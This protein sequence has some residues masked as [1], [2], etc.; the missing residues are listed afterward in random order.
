MKKK[1][2]AIFSAAVILTWC[3]VFA[4]CSQSI[5]KDETPVYTNPLVKMQALSIGWN[6][7]YYSEMQYGSA[8][9]PWV[10]YH[11][12]GYYYMTATYTSTT[13]STTTDGISPSFYQIDIRKSSTINGL[14][15]STETTV[16]NN[17]TLSGWGC[18]QYIWAPELHYINGVWYIFFTA[19]SSS[20]SVSSMR[21]YVAKCVNED[22]VTGTWSFVGQ[23]ASSTING[24]SV[25]GTVFELNNQWY[26]VWAQDVYDGGV[27]DED[28]SSSND[29]VTIHGTAYSDVAGNG[30]GWS[31]LFIGKTNSDDFTTVTDV[32]LI[33]VPLYTWECTGKSSASVNVNEGPA[34]LLRN[35]KVFI[36]YS[37]SACDESYCLGMLTADQ[38]TNLCSIDSW[39]KSSEPVFA[40]SETNCLYGPGHCSF[41]KD[42]NYDVIV[43]HCR[44]YS[45]LYS[46]ATR[47]ITTTKGL[48][49]PWRETHAKVFTWNSDGTPNFG[50]PE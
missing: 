5:E 7:T 23:V 2:V 46:N 26:Y 47:T 40:T 44:P 3:A 34:I 27:W 9:D 35:G 48:D 8:A 1:L 32:T 39:T 36:V 17:S 25:D 19:S 22:P 50:E 13:T 15:N 45:G 20:S 33:S 24:F 38:S 18:Y 16:I 30:N 11:T 4:G 43:Y 29:S 6:T 42:G 37:A 10:Y 41:T 28:G 14:R 21:Q 12:D 49:D 31:C